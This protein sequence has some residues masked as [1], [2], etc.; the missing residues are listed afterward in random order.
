MQR[1]GLKRGEY[2]QIANYVYIQQEINIRI[3]DDAPNE[4]MGDVLYQIESQIPKI[5]G[6]MDEDT[7]MESF[8]QNCIPEDFVH[9]SFED[10]DKFLEE[11]RKIDGR[12]D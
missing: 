10:Y 7:L 2:N 8:R 9:Y 3:K 4:Y 5:G 1:R 12:K 11:R 6:I